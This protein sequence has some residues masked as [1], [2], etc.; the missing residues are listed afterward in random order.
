MNPMLLM[1]G[2][3]AGGNI[4]QGLQQRRDL[5]K[6]NEEIAKARIAQI[7]DTKEAIRY[8]D[9]SRDANIRE[10]ASNME[11]A[12]RTALQVSG[13]AAVSA[14]AAGVR[15]ASVA[16][17][18]DDIQREL[19]DALWQHR[20]NAVMQEFNINQQVWQMG[21]QTIANLP[22]YNKVPSL[23]QTVMRGLVGAGV[24]TGQQYATARFQYGARGA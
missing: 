11:L 9:V 22:Q 12:R 15:G 3:Q 6:Q 21:K 16:A 14:A 5:M 24:S 18:Q 2:A 7:K 10:A 17:V 4:L 23:G 1:F 8:L 13:E 20:Q 19:D